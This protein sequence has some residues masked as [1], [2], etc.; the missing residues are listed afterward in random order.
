MGDPDVGR[1]HL[2]GRKKKFPRL[3]FAGDEAA[4]IGRLLGIQPLLGQHATKQAVL[5]RLQSVSL[6]HLAAHGDVE[7]G[8]I[9]L[10]PVRSTNR[11]PKEEDYPVTMREIAQVQLRA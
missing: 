4:T 7:R 10:S 5:E 6:V 11:I 9:V 1:V 3:P 2:K 8:E